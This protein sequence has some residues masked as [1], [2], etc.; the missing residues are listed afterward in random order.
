MTGT[1]IQGNNEHAILP[2]R[3]EM[4]ICQPR[5]LR[6]REKQFQLQSWNSRGSC[7]ESV[8]EM[9]SQEDPP[10]PQS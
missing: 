8:Q 6:D 10:Q 3:Q 1:V 4:L 5:S 2:P 7:R 9:V